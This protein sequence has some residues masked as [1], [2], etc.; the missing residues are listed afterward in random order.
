MGRP[1][2][3]VASRR[4]FG[5]VLACAVVVLAVATGRAAAQPVEPLPHGLTT[6]P[7]GDAAYTQLAALDNAGCV[8]ARVS[9]HR[10]FR[11]RDVRRAVAQLST[12]AECRGP[13]ADALAAR[14]TRPKEPT[15]PSDIAPDL[16]AA[17]RE[18]AKDTLETLRVGAK[19]TLR[20]TY[21]SRGEFEPLWAG[22]RPRDE[23]TPAIVG[24][25]RG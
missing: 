22:V 1:S 18:L 10:P 6:L 3:V 8:V 15:L 23:G 14:F 7:M 5:R 17:T 25:A 24:D 4:R 19:A 2:D 21:L 13:I 9:A 11:V 12:I 20:A 16:A